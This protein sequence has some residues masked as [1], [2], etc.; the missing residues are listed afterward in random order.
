MCL[1]YGLFKFLMDF[2]AVFSKHPP[3]TSQQLAALTAGDYFTPDPWWDI[4]GVP[5]TPFETALKETFGNE[6]Y[7][8]IVLKP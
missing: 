1:P 8:R 5:Y 4:F 7:S 2:Y 6:K 3:F